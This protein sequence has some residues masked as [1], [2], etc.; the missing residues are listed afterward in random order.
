[1][2][3][4]AFRKTNFC[5]RTGLKKYVLWYCSLFLFLL[6]TGCGLDTYYSVDNNMS[7]IHGPSYE[8]SDYS[9]H[10]FEFISARNSNSGNS[11][12]YF[13]GTEIYYRIYTNTSTL[14]TNNASISS[15]NTTSNY[16]GA[17][18]RLQSLGYK[19]LRTA[20]NHSS[21]IISGN[22][23][24]KKIYIRLTNYQDD[25]NYS[26]RILINGSKLG[27]PRRTVTKHSF[28]FGRYSKDE[29]LNALPLSGDEDASIGGFTTGNV[30]YVDLYAVASGRDTTFTNYYSTVLHLGTVPIDAG[31]E[32]N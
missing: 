6:F 13:S 9:E 20:E 19:E 32:D 3:K 1:M 31:K 7:L 12:F 10:Y 4:T 8:A 5:I 18:Q 15:V 24:G 28:D 23:G 29:V 2:K 30:Y 27:T 22:D 25:A 16:N 14:L 26:A 11:S 21:P 17:F